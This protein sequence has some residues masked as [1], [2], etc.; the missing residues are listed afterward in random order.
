MNPMCHAIRLFLL[1][2]ALLPAFPAGAYQDPAPVKKAVEDYLRIQTKGLPGQVSFTVSSLDPNNQLAPCSSFE[3]SLPPGARVWGRTSLA[4]RCAQEGGWHAFVP[5]HVRI[6]A[7]YLVSA[8]AVTQGQALA[9]A[10]LSSQNGDLADLPSGVLTDPRQAIGRVAAMSIPAGRPLRGD[11]LRQPVV[12]QQG[13]SVKVVSKGA[14]FQVANEGRALNNAADG[15]VAQV[16]L[17]NGQIVSGIARS[18][19]YVEVSY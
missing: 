8:R 7:A 19:G 14:G 16:R 5:V 17:Q 2:T 15:Q 11:M 4:V 12:V 9:E 3:V 10:D 6:F 1:L 13:Q 18:G